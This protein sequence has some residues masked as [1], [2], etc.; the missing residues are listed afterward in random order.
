MMTRLKHI[1]AERDKAILEARQAAAI[2][3]PQVT[4]PATDAAE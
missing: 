1:A 2:P 3:V 4:G